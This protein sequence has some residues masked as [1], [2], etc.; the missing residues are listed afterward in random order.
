MDHSLHCFHNGSVLPF[1]NTIM[2]LIIGSDEFP[3]NGNI[4]G[5]VSKFIW[6]I[7]SYIIW[8]EC[9]AISFWNIIYKGFESLEL[10]KHFIFSFQKLN[11]SITREIIDESYI[12]YMY[13]LKDVEGI[14]L[15]TSE[16]IRYNISFGF[17]SLFGNGFFIFFPFAHPLHIPSWSVFMFGILATTFLTCGGAFY[18]MWQILLCNTSHGLVV[19]WI[20]ASS[21]WT[22]NLYR[23]PSFLPMAGASSREYIHQILL[24]LTSW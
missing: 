18:F 20:K 15:H 9:L 12:I 17:V 3:L 19:S 7:L 6:S 1:R 24:L 14:K 16:C 21:E 22:F 13:P 5:Y 4:F 11:Q 10:S 8:L 2:L 23:N